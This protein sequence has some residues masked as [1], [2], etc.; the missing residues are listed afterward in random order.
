MF[1]KSINLTSRVVKK[2]S[3]NVTREHFNVYIIVTKTN[4]YSKND[5]N[6]D[7][8]ATLTYI[9]NWYRFP[10]LDSNLYKLKTNVCSTMRINRKGM[11][12]SL[13]SKK[14]Y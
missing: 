9:D 7:E 14:K 12:K 11:P 2:D 10:D 3:R 13:K 1:L 4:R 8:I 5:Q 6:F